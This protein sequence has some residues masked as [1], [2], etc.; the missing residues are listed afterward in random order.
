MIPVL[1]VVIAT[2]G[3]RPEWLSEA[4]ASIKLFSDAFEVILVVNGPDADTAWRRLREVH[5]EVTVLACT[6]GGANAARN[7]GLGCASGEF[8][9]FLDDDDLIYCGALG[10]VIALMRQEKLDLCSCRGVEFD[11]AGI[12]RPVT[13]TGESDFLCAV[14]SLQIKS[15]TFMQVFRRQFLPVPAWRES[16]DMAH[17]QLFLFDLSAQRDPSWAV[18]NEVVGAY[19]LHAGDRQSSREAELG[20][21]LGLQLVRELV[22]LAGKLFRAGRLTAARARALRSGSVV[23]VH[24]V[25]VDFPLECLKLVRAIAAL[26]F[27]KN[28]VEA[29]RFWLIFVIKELLLLLPRLLLR[30][31][32]DVVRR[33]YARRTI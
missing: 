22:V 8:I 30:R 26:D 33:R 31:P 14:L 9:L 25:F 3:K 32:L 16:L 17:D 2:L 15:W 10:R 18:S 20:N 21:A 23:C 13:Q 29:L 27:G 1:S 6:R 24:R 4:I 19:R 5:Q 28:G 12:I 11:G 7:T